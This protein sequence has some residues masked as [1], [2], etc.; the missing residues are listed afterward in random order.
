M[1]NIYLDCGF[2]RGI[3]L[4]RYVDNGIID[5]SWDIYVFEPNTDLNVK[6]HIA[7]H[8]GDL[9]VQL[10]EKAVWTKG[11]KVHFH[12]AGREDA[13]SV[14]GTSGHDTPKEITVQAVDFSKFVAKLPEAY[15]I[16][17]MDIEGAEFTVLPKMIKDGTID[18]IDLLEIEFHHRL[19]TD[20]VPDD[21]RKLIKEVEKH[22]VKV[23]LK[24][25]L[26]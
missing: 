9:P 5:K 18:K 17:S 19:M 26:E 1:K 10:I 11:G 25:L 8:F 15:I 16:C 23:K 24:D 22:G 14:E 12:I 21:A 13:A 7:D 20:Y 2:Y 4:R 3:T 6:Q